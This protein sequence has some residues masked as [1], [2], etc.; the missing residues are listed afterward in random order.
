[1]TASPSEGIA[2]IDG[3][4]VPKAEAKISVF[5][6]GFLLSDATYDVAHVWQGAFFRLADHL[7]RFEASLAKLR[8][9]LP[10]DREAIA[11]IA[12]E[13]VRRAGLRDAYVQIIATRGIA[14]DGRRDLRKCTNAFIAFALPFVQLLGSEAANAGVN[15]IISEVLRI[16]PRAVDPTVKN[17][18]RLDFSQSLFEAYDRGADY[19]VLL[20]TDGHV[21]EGLGYNIFALTGDRLVSPASGVLEGVTRATVLEMARETNL[22]A[23]LGDISADQLRGADEIF[24]ATTAGGVTPVTTLDGAPVGGGA[25]GP[26]TLRLQELY[27]AWHDKPEYR[28]P[29]D[30]AKTETAPAA[31]GA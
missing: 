11:A 20:D 2:F 3:A 16:P 31:I 25:A 4:F 21:T 27:W 26:H 18:N 17:F 14:S 15:M 10:Y 22:K 13:C 6:L 19:A 28:T 30:Y 29:I 23:E 24:L 8:L 1:M 12:T 7:D 9:E 5:D